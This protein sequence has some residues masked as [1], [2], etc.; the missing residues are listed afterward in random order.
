MTNLLWSR[1]FAEP[2]PVNGRNAEPLDKPVEERTH[3][4]PR[5]DRTQRWQE[6]DGR[7]GPCFVHSDRDLTVLAQ[8]SNRS[9]H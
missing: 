2:R 9:F 6:N 8:P 4:R 7:A 5:R 3:F 1:P